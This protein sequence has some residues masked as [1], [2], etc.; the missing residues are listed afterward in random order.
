MIRFLDIDKFIKNVTPVTETEYFERSGEFN[1]RGLFSEEIFGAEGTTE[2]KKSFSFINL[3][4]YIVHPYAYQ[5]FKKLD[6]KIIKFFSTEENFSLDK[7][8]KLVEDPEGVTGITN[9]MSLFSKISFRGETPVREKIINF[10]KNAYER[11]SVFI[12]KLPVIPTE[13][14]PAYQDENGDWNFD[15]LNDIYIKI[16]RRTFQI[17]VSGEGIL[18]DLLNYGLQLTVNEHDTYLKKKI[19]KKEGLIRGSMMGKRVDFTGRAVIVPGPD[20]KVNEIG[21][22]FRMAIKIFEPFII[23]KILYN[24]T[25]NDE[26]KKYIKNLN[27]DI[28]HKYIKSIKANDKIEKEIYDIFHRATES[29]MEGRMVLCKRDPALHAESYRAFKPILIDGSVIQLCTMQVGGFNADFDGDQMAIYHPLSNEAQEEVREKMTKSTGGTSSHHLTY[30][31]SKEMCVGLYMMTKDIVSK[32]SPILMTEEGLNNLTDPYISVLYRGVRTTSGRAAVNSC[33]PEDFPF[34]NE[35]VTKKIVNNYLIEELLNKYGEKVTI[36]SISKLE[37][38]G[39][40]FATILSPTISLDHIEMPKEMQV[41]KNKLKGASTDD[42]IKIM[43]EMEKIMKDKLKD[44][45]IGDL[46]ESGSG[47]GWDQ[48]KQIFTAKGV[49]LDPSGKVLDPV[50]NSF[51]DGL[52]A[53]EYFSVSGGARYGMVNRTINTS[54]TGYFTRIL[55][56]VLNSV[57]ADPYLR[58]CK[59]ERTVNLRLTT[60]MIKRLEGRYVVKNNKVELFNK[61]T[62]KAGDSVSLRSPIY[63]ES[64]KIC[65]TCYGRLLL[66]HRSPYIGIIAGTIIGERGTQTIMKDFHT[67][68]AAKFEKRD[69]LGDIINNDPMVNLEK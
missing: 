15:P 48:P 31:I 67:G 50:G 2:R 14:R 54:V 51:S 9:F 30:G 43:E 52:K 35:L 53:T 38:L 55:V 16:L 3:N 12:N 59:T 28:I 27:I 13:Y 22:P 1:P 26:I 19:Q 10:L 42:A 33:L 5:L 23:N 18:Y 6:K 49:V 45:S 64:K 58:D 61:D 60:D 20:L 65:H 4:S 25:F 56:Y 37:R 69:M 21:V 47:K 62:Y 66:R 41:L 39:F 29:A 57:E 8:N 46:I 40:K 7:N 17:K 36:E 63:C 24:K 32:D 44:S 11:N 68:G 34:I